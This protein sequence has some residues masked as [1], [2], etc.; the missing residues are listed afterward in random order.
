MNF[1]N[2][3]FYV[4]MTI[5]NYIAFGVYIYYM[6]LAMFSFFAKKRKLKETGNRKFAIVI[7]AHNEN[8]V[9]AAGIE[10]IKHM[11]YPSELYDIYVI[12]DNCTDNTTQV[13]QAAGAIV[14]ERSDPEHGG[15]G[16]ALQWFFEKLKQMDQGYRSVVILDADNIVH[17]DFLKKINN[18]MNQGYKIV[19][20]YLDSKN[21]FDSAIT[22]FNS[23]EFWVSNR[24]LKLSRDNL[25]LSAQLGG[26]GFSVDMDIL[27]TFGWH[28]TCLTEDLEFTCKLVLNGHKVGWEHE[29]IIYDEKPLT[30]KASWIQRKRWMQ[31]FADVF[32]QYFFPL[33]RKGITTAN[34][35]MID[36]AIYSIQPI[37]LILTGISASYGIIYSLYHLT[38]T[39]AQMPIL[40]IG[41]N[42]GLK[43]A[44]YVI[45]QIAQ[46][47][48]S[49][50]MMF[51]DKKLSLKS[52][53]AYV[54]YPVYLVTWMPIAVLGIL[55]K[56]KKEWAHTEHT[57]AINIRDIDTK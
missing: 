3:T 9:V 51:I 40:H 4:L 7:P 11:D 57:R 33:M 43:E 22:G 12:A 28:A 38:D 46:V 23:I 17:P 35:V 30:L 36:C 42:M 47:L 44:A 49:P 34:F 31:G 8:Q 52:L 54:T 41:R 48:L 20:G 6:F 25:G 32:T 5:I 21:P 10:S 13:A 39:L 29:A 26:T 19:Q 55:H 14:M 56:N 27:R 15:K 53:L 24:M 2:T 18:K 45:L 50:L 1:L 16:Y 37:L